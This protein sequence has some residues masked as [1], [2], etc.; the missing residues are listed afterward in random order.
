MLLNE[1]ILQ[2]LRYCELEKNYSPNTITNREH[3]LRYFLDW[4]KNRPIS[5]IKIK[6]INDY[7]EFLMNW[8]NTYKPNTIIVQETR[9]E[10]VKTIRLLL[11]WADRQGMKVLK[12]Y[13]IESTG[14]KQRRLFFLN[15]EQ[16][17][18]LLSQ[19]N[20]KLRQGKR[21]RAILEVFISTGLR[22]HEMAKLNRADINFKTGEFTITGKGNRVRICFLSKRALFW[23]NNYLE[24]R[25]DDY[26]AL[27]TYFRQ[28]FKWLERNNGRMLKRPIYEI[29]KKYAK[30][31]GLDN[32]I[33]AHT[34]RHSFATLLLQNGANLK[35]VQELMGHKEIRST[36]I[37]LH[38]TNPNLREAHKKYLQF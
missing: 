10:K 35:E 16:I 20:L 9:E 27:F 1:A 30:L 17:N 22:L 25:K 3:H 4:F 7:R 26:P 19:P 32:R 37:Y 2:Y 18:L 11:K 14:N 15:A 34:L 24:T 6:T 38:L 29:V 8:H 13:K 21:D 23:L 33:C 5:K 12:P 31:A 36:E 28:H